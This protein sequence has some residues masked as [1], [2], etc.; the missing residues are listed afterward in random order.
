M[1]RPDKNGGRFLEM[2]KS[3]I[4]LPLFQAFNGP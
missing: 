2:V 4:L 1:T 3:G